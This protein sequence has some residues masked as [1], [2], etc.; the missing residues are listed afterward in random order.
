MEYRPLDDELAAE[1]R[2]IRGLHRLLAAELDLVSGRTTAALSAPTGRERSARWERDVAVHR[3]SERAAQLR[4]ARSGLCFGRLDDQNDSPLYIGRIGL[5]GADDTT[6]ALVDWRAPAARPFYCATLATPMGV[7]RRRHL[8]LSGI[9]PAERVVDIHDDVFAASRT[10]ASETAADPALLAALSAP[11]GTAMRDIVSTIQ[12]EQDAVIRLPLAGTVVVEGG[13]GTGKTAVALHRVAYLMYTHRDRLARRGVLVVGPS[14]PFLDYVG[15]VLPS[16]GESAV[17][18]TTPGRLHRGVEATAVDE[19]AVARLKGDL[20]MCEVLRRAV[21]AEQ[22]LP[23]EPIPLALDAVTVEVDRAVAA[24]AR[25]GARDSARLYNAAR[26]VFAE[27]LVAQLVARGVDAITGGILADPDGV[28]GDA[29]YENDDYAPDAAESAAVIAGDL[30]DDLRDELVDHPGFR[31]VLDRLWPLRTPEQVLA[32]LLA[33][34]ERLA[35][36]AA[37]LRRDEILDVPRADLSALHRP[38][39]AAW[40]VSDAPLL[41]ELA[42]LLGPLPRRRA[43]RPSEAHYAA[44]VLTL[45]DAHDRDLAGEDADELRATD[46]VTADMLADRFGAE[47]TGSLAE[48]AAADREWTY[49]HLVVDEAQELSAMDWHVLARRCPTRSITAVGDLAQRSSPA[50]AEAWSDVLGPVV[51]DRFTHR[52]LTVN[53]RTPAEIMEAAALVL[54]AD[55]RHRVPRSVRRSGEP[56]RRRRA[57]R[58]DFATE[59]RAA[60]VDELGTAGT[61][62]IAVITAEPAAVPELADLG[63]PVVVHTPASAKGLEFDVVLVVDPEAIAAHCRADLYVAMTRATRRLVLITADPA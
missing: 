16:L 39:G 8:L 40:T 2:H 43:R 61:G 6:T 27:A 32:G 45:I 44:E 29:A 14:L 47:L 20:V 11:R 17:V 19:P 54:P 51:G 59:I 18:F 52:T 7:T 21:A 1:T 10:G 25:A 41:D 48:R 53:Y 3:W 4:A 62:M 60:V 63:T 13:P 35:A 49:G 15:G 23:D 46:F 30:A 55:E 50:G 36:I 31:A 5:T 58:A 22:S 57:T 9:A 33:S 24:Q 34:P 42:E 12:S 38:E 26:M 28:D 56:P 37:D